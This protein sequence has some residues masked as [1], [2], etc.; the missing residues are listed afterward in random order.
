MPPLGR[1]LRLICDLG[2]MDGFASLAMTGSAGSI[3]SDTAL[4]ALPCAGDNL[5][6]KQHMTGQRRPAL[7]RRLDRRAR[8]AR[9]E[10]LVRLDIAGAHEMIDMGAEIAVGG[11]GQL[12]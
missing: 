8:P 6:Q 1:A 7:R 10:R 5:L 12:F 2:E 4:A 9:H 3:C 11:A